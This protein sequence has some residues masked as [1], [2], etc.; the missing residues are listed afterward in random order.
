LI[1]NLTQ[2]K[3]DQEEKEQEVKEQEETIIEIEFIL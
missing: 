3:D 2:S 1:I